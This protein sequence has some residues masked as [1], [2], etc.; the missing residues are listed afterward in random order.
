MPGWWIGSSS[1]PPTPTC[2]P[3]SSDLGM[4]VEVLPTVM[5]TD[6]DRRVLGAT[7]LSGG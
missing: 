4:S 1:T 2:G 3:E 7:I 6:D 5:R